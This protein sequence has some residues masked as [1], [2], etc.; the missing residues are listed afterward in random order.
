MA[1]EKNTE[2]LIKIN[3]DTSGAEQSA[4][5]L[6]QK[7]ADLSDDDFGA[8]S[9]K[10]LKKQLDDSKK[11]LDDLKKDSSKLDGNFEEAAA[12]VE[13][14]EKELLKAVDANGKID[15]KKI[16]QLQKAANN[17]AKSIKKMEDVIDDIKHKGNDIFNEETSAK[18][19]GRLEMI[20]G[21]FGILGEA[22]GATV[23]EG[24]KLTGMIGKMS[25]TI[26]RGATAFKGL[27]L[28][29]KAIAIFALISAVALLIDKWDD[30]KASIDRFI[31]TLTKQN[32]IFDKSIQVL[33]GVGNA[34]LK[35]LAA[36]LKTV[37]SLLQGDFKQAFDDFVS[38]WD[39]VT[40]YQAGANDALLRQSADY[41]KKELEQNIKFWERNRELLVAAG[42]DTKEIDERLFK[43][44]QELYADDREKYEELLFEKNKADAAAQ[45]AARDKAK[46]AADKAKADREAELAQVKEFQREATKFLEDLG[47][48]SRQREID[49][50]KAQYKIRIDFAKKH[51]QDYAAIIKEQNAII[52]QI[53]ADYN[54]QINEYTSQ[55]RNKDLDDFQKQTIALTATYIDLLKNATEA[56]KPALKET[57]DYLVGLVD[58]AQEAAEKQKQIDTTKIK[59][60]IEIQTTE[61]TNAVL[62]TDSP[63][64]AKAKLK[65]VSDAKLE[66]LETSY[67]LERDLYADN[68]NKLLELEKNYNDA[69]YNIQQ[70]RIEN[71]KAIDE[72]A[73]EAKLNNI[74][75]V[76][77]ATSGL[78]QLF[79][80][81][82]IAAKALNIA[83]A[84]M[85]TYVGANKALSAYPPPFGAIA[86]AGVIA[87]G[88]ANVKKIISTKVANSDATT[89]A[90]AST[91]T[92]PPV[93]N[94]NVLPKQQTQDVRIVEQ[95]P[96]KEQE[97]L[98]AYI[99]N[100]DLKKQS[101]KNSTVD[102]LSSY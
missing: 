86:A 15:A 62:E 68:Q 18:L 20:G 55:L 80:E 78:S 25:T 10:D 21:E 67:Q 65:A 90:T 49:D 6:G 37:I 39:F 41:R 34:L 17:S 51:K 2:K 97:P 5:A 57:Y 71:E 99:V 14:L 72:A 100:S 8:K 3:L 66:A 28:A 59:S 75:S 101:D 24:L 70:T 63:E 13:R 43:Y 32:G 26:N 91:A 89:A 54:K 31:P 83:T 44:K 1:E 74:L 56:Q 23:G 95:K 45:K 61:R 40:N 96:E 87:T 22:I 79:G 42:K 16:E 76:S 12:A 93:I 88:L 27:G 94:S 38:G 33:Q 81:Q 92:A 84:T 48:S 53:E 19:K 36:P 7:I 77:D 64:V 82:T 30:I 102:R 50:I 58:K 98:R 46:Q 69:V 52:Q 35:F 73:K 4:D 85:D 11:R 29:M 9:V 60:E 47:K